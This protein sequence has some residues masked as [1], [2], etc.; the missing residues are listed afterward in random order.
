MTAYN[1]VRLGRLPRRTSKAAVAGQTLGA[2]AVVESALGT[3]TDPGEVYVELLS[4]VLEDIG[5]RWQQASSIS[6]TS[7]PPRPSPDGS[8]AG[9]GPASPGGADAA[10][11][12]AWKNAHTGT[13]GQFKPGMGRCTV[14]QF[15]NRLR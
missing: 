15:A 3:G 12:T 9:F 6:P 13:G 11:P 5:E 14:E 7:T 2:C 4:P 1:Y 10:A 8:S